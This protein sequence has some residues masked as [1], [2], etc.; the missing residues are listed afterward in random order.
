MD[1]LGASLC[2]QGCYRQN[3]ERIVLAE[4]SAMDGGLPVHAGSN[5]HLP[6]DDLMEVE[7]FHF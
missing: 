7:A 4:G 2:S 6:A 3:S 1:I 5:R